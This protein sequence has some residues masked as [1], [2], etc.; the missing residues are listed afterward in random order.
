MA[1]QKRVIIICGT[2]PEGIKLAP[3]HLALGA[4]PGFRSTLLSTGQHREMLVQALAPFETVPDHDLELMA[5]GQS[6]AEFLSRALVSLDAFLRKDR[7]DCVVVQ[8]DT[9]SAYAGALAAFFARAPLGHVEAGLRTYDL[10]APWPEEM[11]RRAIAPLCRWCFAPTE[12]GRQNLLS[13][14]ID[15]DRVHVTGNTVI[16]ALHLVRS[17]ARAQPAEAVA[18]RLGLP[19]AFTR[20]FLVRDGAWLLVTGHR[21]ESFG[22]GFDD[23][24]RALL[25]IV[26]AHP[27]L[28]IVYPVHLNPAVR[29]PVLK[30]L[31]GHT[32][33]A[34]AEPAKYE[35]FVWLMDR[36]RFVLSDSGGV[37]EEAPSLG[38]PVLV[39]REKTERPEAIAAGTCT[40]VGTDPDRIFTEAHRLLTDGVEFAR[41]SR[42]ANPYG[43]GHAVERIVS[44]LERDLG[45]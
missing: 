37:Q 8:G 9:S 45:A 7:P 36:C 20:R 22:K 3:L 28:G 14:R 11:Y 17:R 26:E 32:R 1:G 25:K 33:I 12:Q 15:P 10:D 19:D 34:L 40:L 4:H 38:K 41:R 35:D 30:L 5:P 18:A 16:D 21:R 23:I 29:V 27:E 43:D 2:R 39:L 24:C 6:P 13:E 44:V 31:G 42:L